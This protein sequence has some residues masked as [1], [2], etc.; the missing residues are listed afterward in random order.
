V[1][2]LVEVGDPSEEVWSRCRL[3]RGSSVD[4]VAEG[5]LLLALDILSC[6]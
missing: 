5:G 3:D 6:T 1:W 2:E 4:D